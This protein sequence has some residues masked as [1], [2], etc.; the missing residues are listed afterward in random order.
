MPRAHHGL[1]YGYPQVG[2]RSGRNRAPRR[3]AG[4]RRLGGRAPQGGE[5]GIGGAYSPLLG[6]DSRMRRHRSSEPRKRPGVLACVS[7]ARHRGWW[8]PEEIDAGIHVRLAPHAA[9]PATRC[10]GPLEIGRSYLPRRERLSSRSRTRSNHVVRCLPREDA[11]RGVGVRERG[12]SVCR[13]DTLRRVRWTNR[14]AHECAKQ[15][16]GLSDSGL[17]TIFVVRL[18]PWGLPIRQQIVLAGRRVDVLIGAR[19]VVQI[20]G[21][22]YHSIQP[23][24]G[25]AMSRMNAE[26]SLRGYTVL[27]FTYAQIVH[28]WPAVNGPS[29]ARSPR[30]PTSP[31]D[32]GRRPDSDRDGRFGSAPSSIRIQSRIRSCSR[33]QPTDHSRADASTRRA[34]RRPRHPSTGR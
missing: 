17:E 29:R 16:N 19:L 8:M 20:D 31:R 22:A 6:R 34:A 12:P 32:F 10:C 24:T 21:F 28:D 25:D 23:Q 27:R 14:L 2:R 11:L 5:R 13:S 4:H 1:R 18:R 7:A 26:L 9:A 15:V 30:A 33:R 3:P